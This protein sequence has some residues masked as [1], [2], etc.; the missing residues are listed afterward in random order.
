MRQLVQERKEAIML[1]YPSLSEAKILWQPSESW[2]SNSNLMQFSQ[3]I[4]FSSSN[5]DRLHRWS[6]AK[7][8]EFWSAM[9]DFAEVIPSTK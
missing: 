9:W 5:Y 4:G 1:K 6:I 7:P 2:I 8:E 3:Q